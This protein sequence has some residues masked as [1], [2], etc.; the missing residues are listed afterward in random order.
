[1]YMVMKEREK[2]RA[3]EVEGTEGEEVGRK[4]RGKEGPQTESQS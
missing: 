1:M 2:K 4:G 3:G